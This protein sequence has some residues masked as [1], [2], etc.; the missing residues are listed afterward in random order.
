[1]EEVDL[2]SDILSNTIISEVDRKEVMELIKA[3]SN[4]CQHVQGDALDSK[5]PDARSLSDSIV[6]LIASFKIN[7]DGVLQ[8]PPPRE[9]ESAAASTKSVALLHHV[10]TINHVKQG[11]EQSRP[12]FLFFKREITTTERQGKELGELETKARKEKQQLCDQRAVES[13][14]EEEKLKQ[15]QQEIADLKAKLKTKKE[16][17]KLLQEQK[18]LKEKDREQSDLDQE[19]HLKQIMDNTQSTNIQL[20]NH[21]K[22]QEWLARF[23]GKISQVQEMEV[24]ECI[25]KTK[26]I[27]VEQ[28]KEM[29]FLEEK[30]AS[31]ERSISLFSKD[32]PEL[33]GGLRKLFDR[34]QAVFSDSKETTARVQAVLTLL[35]KVQAGKDQKELDELQ[36]NID[37]IIGRQQALGR[38]YK[39]Q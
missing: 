13:R 4:S 10:A 9:S 29:I 7:P 21:Q 34:C 18:A 31:Y 24:L 19:Q 36:L 25:R 3:F 27:L 12:L 2:L 32:E 38:T 33:L 14:E 28:E 17:E 1:M 39:L 11:T 8:V 16:E 23:V 35:K 5:N 15:L 26:D 37:K 30:M 6:S 20:E 22:T